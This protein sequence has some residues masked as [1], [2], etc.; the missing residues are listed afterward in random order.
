MADVLEGDARAAGKPIDGQEGLVRS[1]IGFHANLMDL[2]ASIVRDTVE[3]MW[4]SGLAEQADVIVVG[5]EF[6]TD[7]VPVRVTYQEATQCP[8][9][10]IGLRAAPAW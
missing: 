2:S 6:V 1:A 8:A 9:S 3:G 4:V 7:G 5:Q 10:S